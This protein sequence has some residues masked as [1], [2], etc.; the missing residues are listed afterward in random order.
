[1]SI[2]MNTIT[3][4]VGDVAPGMDGM[5]VFREVLGAVDAWVQVY[6]A[7]TTKRALIAAR[8]RA[9]I[10]EIQARRDLFLAY[11]DRAFDERESNFKELF[12]A[13]DTALTETPDQVAVVLGSITALAAKSPFADL[14]DL[15]L[16]KQ[17]LDDPEHEWSA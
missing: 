16:V 6:E 4:L 7:E 3:G 13:L 5:V 9:I 2:D 11:L 15:D 1:M 8:E 10:G 17:H 12:R 14:S